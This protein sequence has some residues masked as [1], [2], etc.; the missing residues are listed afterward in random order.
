MWSKKMMEEDYANE[1]IN[2]EKPK[3]ENRHRG[4]GFE[5]TENRTYGSGR[6]PTGEG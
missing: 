1:V 5:D 4:E 2:A 3:G 6:R